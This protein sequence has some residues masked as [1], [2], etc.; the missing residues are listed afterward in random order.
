MTALFFPWVMTPFPLLLRIY[1]AVFLFANIIS[2]TSV[3]LVTSRRLDELV[4]IDSLMPNKLNSNSLAA[5]NHLSLRAFLPCLD[6]PSTH[7]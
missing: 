4:H 3:C 1:S 7:H 5:P 2:F 6:D